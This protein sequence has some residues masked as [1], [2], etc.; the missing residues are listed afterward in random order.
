MITLHHL[1]QSRSL[2]IIWALEELGLEYQIKHYKR[3]PTLAAP[4]ELKAVH[5]LGK[6][7]VLTDGDLTI[8]ESA[9]I[10]DYLQTTYDSK[11][12]FKPQN[13][14]DLM[15]YNYWMHYAEGSLMP[16]LVM[17]LVMTNM[18]K[19]VPFLIRP[20]AKK[21]SEGVRGGF[22]N[23]RLKEHSAFL[24]D[25]FSQHDYAAGEFSFAD[26]QMSFPVIAMQQRTQNK[27]PQ[28]AAYAERIQQRP[29]Y[30]R[31]KAKSGD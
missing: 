16:Y 1:D 21:I 3:L 12:Q 9:V 20:I 2:R 28:I 15:Q 26:I 5:P 10:L 27:M 17:T 13:P 31:A 25:Y 19:H 29:A 14:Q 11:N 22:I 4:P 7:P 23:P 8:A 30:Q 18:P 6:S 24:E